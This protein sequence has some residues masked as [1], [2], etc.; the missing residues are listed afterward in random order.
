MANLL[1][2]NFSGLSVQEPYK[3]TVKLKFFGLSI[4]KQKQASLKFWGLS[5]DN[6]PDSIFWYQVT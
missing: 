6:S 5:A 3:A 2:L 4:D 1:K